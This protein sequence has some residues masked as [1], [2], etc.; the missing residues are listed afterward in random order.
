[1]YHRDLTGTLAVTSST[2]KFLTHTQ[3]QCHIGQ[4]RNI[5]AG[6]V[7]FSKREGQSAGHG[8]FLKQA[9]GYKVSGWAAFMIRENMPKS[10][11]KEMQTSSSRWLVL[12]S[13]SSTN[14]SLLSK[15]RGYYCDAFKSFCKH[16]CLQHPTSPT[17]Q[18]VPSPQ[19][20]FYML[21]N[22]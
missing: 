5:R 22:L 1:M 4:T 2:G 17:Y 12:L 7:Y 15:I 6:W 14:F 13:F 11:S 3:T 16:S 8:I 9:T 20:R 21:E 10:H 19:R 18:R